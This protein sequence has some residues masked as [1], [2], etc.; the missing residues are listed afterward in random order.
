MNRLSELNFADEEGAIT[1]IAP[2]IE[3]A[4]EIAIR[5]A[6]H[7]PFRSSD[8]LSQAIRNELLSL[9]EAERIDLFRAHADLAPDNPLAMTSESQSEQGRLNLTSDQGKYQARLSE[10]NTLYHKK[11]GFPFITALVRHSDIESVLMEFEAR[12]AS[13]RNSEIAQTIHQIAT[14][15][16]SRVRASFGSS[17]TH[18]SDVMATNA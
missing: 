8:N 2:L 11:Y 1:M 7:R 14:V 6:S 9:G 3:R 13:D 17:D 18:S 15:S 5:V 10:L 4:P 16:S 12:L